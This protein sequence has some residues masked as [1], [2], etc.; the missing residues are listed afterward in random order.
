M[1]VYAAPICFIFDMVTDDRSVKAALVSGLKQVLEDG[2]LI[3]LMHD[4]R[5]PAAAIRYQLQI[6]LSNVFDTQVDTCPHHVAQVSGTVACCHFLHMSFLVN[7]AF[8]GKLCCTM[9]ATVSL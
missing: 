2:S 4:C 5:R 7:S 1:Q 3:K 6:S 8:G 9:H